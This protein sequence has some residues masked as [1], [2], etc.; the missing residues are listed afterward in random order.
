MTLT[1]PPP[2]P[3]GFAP[4]DDSPESHAV[5]KQ[6]VDNMADGVYLVDLQR[7][8]TYWNQAAERITG[9]AGGEVSGRYCADGILMHVDDSGQILCGTQCPLLH[10]MRDGDVRTAEV[11]LHHKQGHRV[12]VTIRAAP[13]RDRAGRIVGSVEVFSDNSSKLAAL[14]QVELLKKVALIDPVTGVGNRRFAEMNLASVFSEFHRYEWS[15]GILFVDVDDF[16]LFND[17]FGHD[18][19]DRVLRMVARTL[20]ANLRAF[21]FIGRWGGEEFLITALNLEAAQ[22]GQLAERL[23]MLAE[24]SELRL[25]DQRYRVTVSVGATLLREGDTPETA[26]QRADDLMYASKRAGKNRVATDIPPPAAAAT[27]DAC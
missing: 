22:L 6:V 10:T 8:I 5:Y 27:S 1:P 18:V 23:R 21:D 2:K 4:L 14:E 3:P 15:A 17:R 7:R 16:K 24:R 20:E 13:L 25:G 19:G 9:F 11:Y 12:P 26:V